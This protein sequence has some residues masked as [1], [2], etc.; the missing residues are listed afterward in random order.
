MEHPNPKRTDNF[1][2]IVTH[3]ITDE[4]LTRHNALHPKHPYKPTGRKVRDRLSRLSA[5]IEHNNFEALQFAKKQPW[6]FLKNEMPLRGVDS[7]GNY[8]ELEASK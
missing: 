4:L 6:K 2:N 3:N 1:I 7:K 5:I 8:V